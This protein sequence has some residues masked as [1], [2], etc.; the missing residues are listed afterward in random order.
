MFFMICFI[1]AAHSNMGCWIDLDIFS[2]LSKKVFSSM[3]N[4]AIWNNRVSSIHFN[5]QLLNFELGTNSFI[6]TVFSNMKLWNK[7][8]DIRIRNVNLSIVWLI[9]LTSLSMRRII[10]IHEYYF[11][12]CIPKWSL[13][14]KYRKY[15]SFVK[16]ILRIISFLVYFF[17]GRHGLNYSTQL[18]IRCI[19]HLLAFA[20]SRKIP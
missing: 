10:A 11:Y 5:S 19:P 8:K 16:S 9:L 13:H 18:F 4:K 14:T 17:S 6:A 1:T 15:I 3:R 12:I 2:D 7:S 20:F